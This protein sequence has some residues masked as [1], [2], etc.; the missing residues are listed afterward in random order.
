M[1]SICVTS[2]EFS[3]SRMR[4]TMSINQPLGDFFLFRLIFPRSAIKA[5]SSR[6]YTLSESGGQILTESSGRLNNWNLL[7][8]PCRLHSRLESRVKNKE[9]FSRVSHY[10]KKNDGHSI[11]R[12]RQ[13]PAENRGKKEMP[14]MLLARFRVQLLSTGDLSSRCCS[15]CRCGLF[16]SVTLSVAI[17]NDA[18]QDL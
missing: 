4:E 8:S 5:P 16:S 1:L 3:K 9:Q 10:Y 14:K 2:G 7:L 12:D 13:P 17:V 11:R 6:H 18:C 15:P